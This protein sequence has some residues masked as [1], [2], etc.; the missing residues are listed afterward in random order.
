MNTVHIKNKKIICLAIE[1]ELK[2]Q[3]DKEA[4]KLGMTTNGY[5]RYILKMRLK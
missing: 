2:K 1:E 4:D 5:I 3:L